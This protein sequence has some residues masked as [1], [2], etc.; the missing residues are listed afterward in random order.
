MNHIV[1]EDE[2][3]FRI[4]DMRNGTFIVQEDFAFGW[5]EIATCENIEAARQCVGDELSKTPRVVE[6]YP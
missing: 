3:K 2:R 6:Q 1:T 5:R 4:L